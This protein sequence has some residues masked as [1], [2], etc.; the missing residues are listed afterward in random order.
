M[1]KMLVI[2][3]ALSALVLS[4][5]SGNRQTEEP[6]QYT[7]PL[8]QVSFAPSTFEESVLDSAT[9]VVIAQY[10]ESRLFGRALI[11]REFIVIAGYW[12]MRRTGYLFITNIQMFSY[13]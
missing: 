13:I 12:A 5:C 9:D 8:T 10:V 6:R 11:E 3:L 1:K 2:L 7:I 4:A